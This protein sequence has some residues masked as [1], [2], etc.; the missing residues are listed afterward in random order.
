MLED[1]GGHGAAQ[2]LAC[3]DDRLVCRFQRG[4]PALPAF[5]VVGGWDGLVMRQ[6]IIIRPALP[7]VLPR[8]ACEASGAYAH[9]LPLRTMQPVDR[10]RH[11]QRLREPAAEH[12]HQTVA[13]LEPCILDVAGHAVVE[14]GRTEGHEMPAGLQ[15][16]QRL[17]PHLR[18]R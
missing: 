16:P 1:V 7:R 8:A 13:Q 2:R 14:P 18:V 10:L 5:G 3:Q 12:P 11:V 15:N 9:H 6:P 17:P 4:S